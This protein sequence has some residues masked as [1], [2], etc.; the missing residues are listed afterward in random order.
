MLWFD[1][2]YPSHA[3]YRFE[4][5][6]RAALAADR[7]LFVGT[8]FSVGVTDAVLRAALARRVPVIAIDPGEAALP[9]GV[10]RLCAKAEEVLPAAAAALGDA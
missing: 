2:L 5:V 1:E 9:R 8:S 10:E 4:E 6:V 7:V 3:D